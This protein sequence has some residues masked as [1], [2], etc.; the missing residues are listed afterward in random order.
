MSG[1]KNAGKVGG[2]V[3]AG[4]TALSLITDD[5]DHD[6]QEVIEETAK[7][8]AVGATSGA[9]GFAAGE[10]LAGLIAASNPIAGTAAVIGGA[11]VAS[12]VAATF[13]KPVAEGFSTAIHCKN[14]AFIGYGIQEGIDDV[15]DRI[16]PLSI[17]SGLFGLFW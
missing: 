3:S 15:I 7:S 13:V 5:E 12:D 17:L 9:A 11:V 14:P 10:C 4:L 16:P 1:V 8:A 2:I 6:C